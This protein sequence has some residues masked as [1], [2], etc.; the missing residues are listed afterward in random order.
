MPEN[1]VVECKNNLPIL[2][3]KNNK[4]IVLNDSMD[5]VLI[6]GDN[7]HSLSVLN[8]THSEAID[9]I[10]ID[11]PYNT[12]KEGFIYNDKRVNQDDTYRHSKWLNFMEKRLKLARDL[13]KKDGIIFISN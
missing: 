8:Y 1:V 6:V 3:S 9:V 13:L 11:P 10:Y 5:N 2:R 7:Y 4:D 12:L